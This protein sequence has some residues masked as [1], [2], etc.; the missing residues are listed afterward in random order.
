[1]ITIPQK[2]I[3]YQDNCVSFTHPL[4]HA[5][6]PPQSNHMAFYYTQQKIKINIIHSLKKSFYLKLGMTVLAFFVVS[7]TAAPVSARTFNPHNIIT[8]AELLNKN[9]LSKTAIQKFLERE[10][11]VLARYSQIVNGQTK[12]TS[13][14][15][16]ELAQRHN[17]NPKFLLTNLEKEQGLIQKNQA[18][19]KALDWAMGYSCYGGS[20]NEKHRGLYNQLDAAAETQQIYLARA[21]QFGFAVGR[22]TLTFDGYKV[23]PQNNA[24]A[25]L[26]I[27]TPYVGNAPELGINSR[28]GANKLFWRIWHRYFSNQ[29]FVDGQ[30]ITFDGSYY[31]I[32]NNAK[33]KFASKNLFLKDYKENDA[34]NVSSKDLNAYPNGAPINFANNTL[35]KSSASGQIFLLNGSIKRPILNN[36]ALALLSDFTIA[37][38]ESEIPTVA[39]SLIA[40]YTLGS[41]IDV[42]TVHPQGKLFKDP[43]GQIWQI[44]DGL[45]HEVDPVVWQHNFGSKTP[46]NIS[47]VEPYPTG[48]PV[49][50]KDG[51]FVTINGKYY[52]ISQGDRQKINDL[53]IFNRTFGLSKKN[54][55]LRVS[56]ALLN[57]HPAGEII[58][59]IDDTI[60]DPPPNTTPTVVSGTYSGNFDSMNPEGLIMVNGQSQSVTLKFKNNGTTWQRGNIYL[61][62]TDKG[63]NA[64]S[65]NAPIKV[66]M[67]ESSV[68]SSQVASFTVE[69]TAPTDKTGLQNQEFTLMYDKNNV[70]TK[71]ASIGKFII[72]KSGIAAQIVNHNIPIAV[73]NDWKPIDIEMNIKNT[74]ADVTWLSRRTA[75]ELRHH[76]GTVSPFYDLNDWVRKEVVGVPLNG[77]TI[78]PGETGEF[79]F[80]LDP[81][82]VKPGIYVLTFE[83]KLLDKEK[84]VYLSGGLQWKREIRVD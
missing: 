62:T 61:K 76:D 24:T 17:I 35:V 21:G 81:R 70:P 57:V 2:Y 82:G 6:I 73:R 48:E 28:F 36:S 64:S 4:K 8:D 12:K 15:I 40:S 13:E 58:D 5:K 31:L 9:S 50:L 59:Y 51:T 7:S 78:K 3:K 29:K 53:T 69:L 1:M 79:K 74:S 32:Q 46:E 30:I 47:S 65:F 38:T 19:E 49:K 45:K 42:T 63:S 75:L 25:N 27:Y 41:S 77:A 68:S 11:S 33:K 10:N 54:S 52:I 80:T 37:V 84:D 72:I 71:I 83:L 67:N 60:Q 20:C 43:S 26:Y 56:T 39:D 44:K 23:T 22:E 16:W 34:I 14:M 66:E 18:T 55:A